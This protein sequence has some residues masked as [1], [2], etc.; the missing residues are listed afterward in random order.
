[1]TVNDEDFYES[2]LG[3]KVLIAWQDDQAAGAATKYYEYQYLI[4]Q[5]ALVSGEV[6]LLATTLHNEKGI[7]YDT[8]WFRLDLVHSISFPRDD[9]TVGETEKV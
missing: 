5:I 1:V 7:I 6:W 4:R 8:H 2:I 3:K 9:A